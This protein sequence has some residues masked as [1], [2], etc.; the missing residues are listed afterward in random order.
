[1]LKIKQYSKFIRILSLI[2]SDKKTDNM[3]KTDSYR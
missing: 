2:S 3:K 1:M